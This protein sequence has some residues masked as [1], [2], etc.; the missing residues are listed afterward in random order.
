VKDRFG[1]RH[2]GQSSA[3]LE[4]TS[5]TSSVSAV[6]CVRL[7]MA[8]P[9]LSKG[10]GRLAARPDR[11]YPVHGRRKDQGGIAQ[12]VTRCGWAVRKR[13]ELHGM[14]FLH[15]GNDSEFVAREA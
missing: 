6:G 10:L 11:L 3:R 5:R 12:G 7:G 1:P 8:R 14:T 4:A 9:G 13:A 2:C 15:R